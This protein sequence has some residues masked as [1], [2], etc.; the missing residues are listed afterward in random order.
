[1]TILRAAVESDKE[2]IFSLHEDLFRADIDQIWGWNDEWQRENFLTEWDRSQTEVIE[3]DGRMAGYLQ[4]ERGNNPEHLYVLSFAISPEHQGH[5]VGTLVMNTLMR[6]ATEL[7][8]QIRLNVF[9]TNPSAL[10]FYLRLGFKTDGSTESGVKLRWS[11]ET[12]PEGA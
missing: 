5:G 4:T 3:C 8:L 11:G 7:R 12:L 10:R 6:R 2:T 9:R 1:M